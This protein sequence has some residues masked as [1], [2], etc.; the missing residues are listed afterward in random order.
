MSFVDEER[1]LMNHPENL[2]YT[3]DLWTNFLPFTRS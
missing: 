2:M 3:S 1:D